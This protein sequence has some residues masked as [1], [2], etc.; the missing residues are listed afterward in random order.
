MLLVSTKLCRISKKCQTF[1]Y[2][3]PFPRVASDRF[4]ITYSRS[5]NEVFSLRQIRTDE[6]IS[7]VSR[8]PREAFK[9]QLLGVHIWRT[10]GL[11]EPVVPALSNSSLFEVSWT[12]VSTLIHV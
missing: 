4:I 3:L 1:A 9:M 2:D 7:L 6:I 11:L 8:D 10:S 12:T 5:Y